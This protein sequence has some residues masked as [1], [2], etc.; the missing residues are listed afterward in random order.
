MPAT[1]DNPHLSRLQL[2]A[3]GEHIPEILGSAHSVGDYI[4]A[5]ISANTRR[6]YRADLAHFTAWGGT[7]PSTAEEVALYIA[8]HAEHLTAS[9]LAR[10]LA[11]ISTAHKAMG[12]ASPPSDVRVAATMRG[13]RRVHGKGQRQA[14]PLLIE[15]LIAILDNTGAALRDTRDKA[16][17]LV[18]FAGALRR[19]ELVGLDC[20]DLEWCGQG[21]ILHLRRSKTDADGAGRKIGIPRAKGRHCPVHA[22]REWLDRAKIEEGAAFRSIRNTGAVSSSRLS[23]E[24]VSLIVKERVR[25]IGFKAEEYSGH[26]L[27][28]G[29]A[30]SAAAAGVAS[31]KIRQQTGHA[32]DEMLSRY[33]R[34][35]ELFRGNAAGSLL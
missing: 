35:G 19:S 32:S 9:T 11:A 28:A 15:D 25:A 26:S 33:I 34:D 2:G 31:W 10:R 4:G 3:D 30:T 1:S 22:M 24:A 12:E 27:R 13:I 18:G 21:L 8:A 29:L 6:A 20:G 14:R 5:A 17:L 16:L 23:G 7:I